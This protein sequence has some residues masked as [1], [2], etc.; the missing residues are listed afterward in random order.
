[1]RMFIR[2][3]VMSGVA[4]ATAA[5]P[6]MAQQEQPP[7]PM[8]DH[9]EHH[10]A[11]DQPAGRPAT[12]GGMMDQG[13]MGEGMMGEGAQGKGGMMGQG[14]MGK[15][16]AG[17]MMGGCPMEDM[18][19][20]GRR[21]KGHRMG[22]GMDMHSVPMM[23]GRLAYLKADLEITDAQ[24]S[25][26]DGYANAVRTGRATM[27]GVHRDMMESKKSAALE[28]MDALIKAMD[29]KVESLKALKPATEALYAVLTDG[30]KEKADQVLGGACPLM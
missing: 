21:G 6:A 24:A 4:I 11:T 25:A 14:M 20:S 28:R 15:G 17:M 1:M 10:G 7:A 30:Q 8:E 22:Q 29:S 23:E 2:L 19:G 27:E 18:M 16:K 26:W 12:G 5:Y 13:T 9:G 3:M